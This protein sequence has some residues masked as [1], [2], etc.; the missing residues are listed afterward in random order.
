MNQYLEVGRQADDGQ[1]AEFVSLCG[2]Q[3]G[4]RGCSLYSSRQE[5]KKKKKNHKGENIPEQSV[6]VTLLRVKQSPVIVALLITLKRNI[7]L[8]QAGECGAVLAVRKQG[9]EEVGLQR[10]CLLL[11]CSPGDRTH[12]LRGSSSDSSSKGSTTQLCESKCAPCRRDSKGNNKVGY[13]LFPGYWLI[14]SINLDIINIPLL[15]TASQRS[16]QTAQIKSQ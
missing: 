9:R 7:T 10:L 16:T 2:G 12:T 6:S 13:I 5:H 4:K 8:R 14:F 3:L 11:P 15:V 1:M